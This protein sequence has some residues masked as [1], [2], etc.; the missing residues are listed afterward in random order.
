LDIDVRQL[1]KMGGS[2]LLSAVPVQNA[3][4][5]GLQLMKTFRDDHSAWIIYLYRVAP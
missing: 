2:Y 3:S 4:S 1:K 5:I